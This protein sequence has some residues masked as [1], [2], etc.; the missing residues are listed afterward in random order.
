MELTATSSVFWFS[1]K[2]VKSKAIKKCF[3]KDGNKLNKHVGQ[4][5]ASL[6]GPVHSNCWSGKL[7]VVLI[8]H[9]TGRYK[10]I[11]IHD[12]VTQIYN[13]F[14]KFDL[15]PSISTKTSHTSLAPTDLLSSLFWSIN[16]M[17]ITDLTSMSYNQWRWHLCQWL[18]LKTTIWEVTHMYREADI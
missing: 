9:R 14:F 8:L 2:W 5:E 13:L 1:S 6:I 3:I 15:P 4:S 10:C 17:N 12:A 18:V 16:Y 11:Y 7:T